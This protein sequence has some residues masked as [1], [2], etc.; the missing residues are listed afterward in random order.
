MVHR[1]LLLRPA[2]LKSVAGVEEEANVGTFDGGA[3]LLR[4]LFHPGLGHV[5]AEDD[6]ELHPP[7]YL[8]H[9]LRVVDGLLERADAGIGC[10]VDDERNAL[11]RGGTGGSA[12][13]DQQQSEESKPVG[14]LR[15]LAIP[16]NSTPMRGFT[17]YALLVT[18]P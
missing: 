12:R 8:R 14:C 3:K 4:Q 1:M 13:K 15:H 18:K 5:D 6:L 11:F 10:I 2:R 9:L 17:T 7:Q 16:Q